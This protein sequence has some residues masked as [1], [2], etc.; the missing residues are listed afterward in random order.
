MFFLYESNESRTL[1]RELLQRYLQTVGE[2]GDRNV[3]VG[4]MP[5]L[6]IDGT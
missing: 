3:R 1:F 2:K 6:M 5:Q 4:A